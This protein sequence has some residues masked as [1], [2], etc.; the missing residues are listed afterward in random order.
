MTKSSLAKSLASSLLLAGMIG[1]VTAQAAD[2]TLLS[3][4]QEALAA[5]LLTIKSAQHSIDYM[6][7]DLDPCAGSA[8]VV[9]DALAEKASQ[10]RVVRLLVDGVSAN[11]NAALLKSYTDANHINLGLFKGGY[12]S[13]FAVRRNHAKLLSVDAGTADATYIALSRNLTDAYYG[14]DLKG[15]E[16]NMVGRDLLV[17][18]SSKTAEV[19]NGFNKLWNYVLTHHDRAEAVSLVGT[20]LDPARRAKVKNATSLHALVDKLP[21]HSCETRFTIDD[22]SFFQK[23]FPDQD[24]GKPHGAHVGSDT[25]LTPDRMAFKHM[26]AKMIEFINGT[27]SSLYMENQYFIPDGPI[28]D[29]LETARDQRGVNMV[30]FTN[31]SVSLAAS[32]LDPSAT[33]LSREVAKQFSD[34]SPNALVLTISGLGALAQTEGAATYAQNTEWYIHSKAAVRDNKDVYIGSF[35]FDNYS[36]ADNVEDGVIAYNCPEVAEEL[37]Q[38]FRE[39]Y[40]VYQTDAQSCEKCEPETSETILNPLTRVMGWIARPLF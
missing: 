36:M 4:G 12:G 8:Q 22:P 19:L 3:H 32:M 28:M 7:W 20:C 26:T 17:K 1:A 40:K 9:L 37:K 10:G 5:Q 6:T 11:K 33:H 34:V 30:T 23:R 25:F 29:A 38:D 18:D 13:R 14:M 2:V 31:R 24:D 21:H 27:K 39:M 16:S 35:N 15:K